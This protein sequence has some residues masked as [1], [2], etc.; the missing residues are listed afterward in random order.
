MQISVKL[1]GH[2]RTD[3]FK[4][5]VREYP[6]GTSVRTCLK[7]LKIPEEIPGIVLVN[8]MRGEM[9]LEL[10]EGDTLALFPLVSGG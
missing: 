10:H 4:E 3:R 7:E 8:G 6:A 5:A 9:D 1:F 2:F